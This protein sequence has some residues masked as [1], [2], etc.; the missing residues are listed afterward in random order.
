MPDNIGEVKMPDNI[1]KFSLFW[2]VFISILVAVTFIMQL[3]GN[4]IKVGTT[5]ELQSLQR[6]DENLKSIESC[7]RQV[8]KIDNQVNVNTPG[9]IKSDVEG[10]KTR[11]TTIEVQFNTTVSSIFDQISDIKSSMDKIDRYI[12]GSE[13]G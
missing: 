8:N 7:A 1:G 4:F 6:I 11:M 13:G 2:Q 9:T 10:L 5:T 12:R 3:Y